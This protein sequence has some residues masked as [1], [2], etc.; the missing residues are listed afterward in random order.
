[1]TFSLRSDHSDL[2]S[3][4]IA[5]CFGIREFVDANAHCAHRRDVEGQCFSSLQ[6]PSS[7][8][9]KSVVAAGRRRRR[10]KRGRFDG[11][12]VKELTSTMGALNDR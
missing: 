8:L 7:L 1:M 10:T 2:T 4:D 11:D 9:R 6:R 5:D 12:A 3:Q